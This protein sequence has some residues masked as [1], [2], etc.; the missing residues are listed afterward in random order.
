MRLGAFAMV[1]L[2]PG[3][4]Q[5]VTVTVD[6]RLLAMFRNGQWNVAPGAYRG[7]LGASSRD[8]RETVTVRLPARR[9]PA[10]WRPQRPV[11]R[12]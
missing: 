8:L 9:L 11:R 4:R 12:R 6:P 3:A 10:G 2:A 5:R 1:R 7:R